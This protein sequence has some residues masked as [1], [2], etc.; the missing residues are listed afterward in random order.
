[1]ARPLHKGSIIGVQPSLSEC[2][3][4]RPTTEGLLVILLAARESVP[5][6]HVLMQWLHPKQT[7]HSLLWFLCVEEQANSAMWP[8]ASLAHKV[9]MQY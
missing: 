7:D 8:S 4:G 9:Q 1:M 3:C 6:W 5:L 2:L